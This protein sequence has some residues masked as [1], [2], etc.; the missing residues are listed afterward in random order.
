MPTNR[1]MEAADAIE[2]AR[3]KAKLIRQGILD[4]VDGKAI[5]RRAPKAPT[6][7]W[8][9]LDGGSGKVPDF[10]IPAA[11]PIRLKTATGMTSFHFSHTAVSKVTFE[12]CQDGLRNQPGAA[13]SH[14][15]Y[16]ERE[17]AVAT[18]DGG[19]GMGLEQQPEPARDPNAY[20]PFHPDAGSDETGRHPSRQQENDNEQPPVSRTAEADASRTMVEEFPPYE[21][22]AGGRDGKRSFEDAESDADLQL[23]SGRDLVCDGWGTEHF[24]LGVADVSVETGEG[25]HGLRRPPTGDRADG[26]GEVDPGWMSPLAEQDRYLTRPSSLAILVATRA[27]VTN[28]DCDDDERANF[29]TTVEK[30]ERKPSPDKMKFRGDDHPEFWEHVLSREDCPLEI[31][32]KLA[33]PNR[34]SPKAFTIG[35][36]KQVRAWLR[37]QPGWI[38]P[39]TNKKHSSSDPDAAPLAEF[40][41]GRGGRVQY[42]IAAELPDELTPSQNFALLADFVREFEERE[43]PFVAVMHAPDEHN[44]RKNWHFHIAYYDRPCR[45]INSDDIDQLAHKGFNVAE[46][47]PGMWDFAVEVPVPGRKNRTTFPLR[48]NKV[49]EVSGSKEWPKT[50]RVA[51]AKVV[52]RHLADAGI[53]RRVSPETFEQMGVAADPQEHLGTAQ[54]ALETR[55]VATLVGIENERK[56]WQAIQAQA[57]ARYQADLSEAEAACVR[58]MIRQSPTNDDALEMRR[59]LR[60]KLQQ[61]AKLKYDAL[62]LDQEMERAASRARMVRERNLQLVKA[63]DADPQNA[64]QR[65]RVEH[66]KLVRQA[67]QYLIELEE[68]QADDRALATR[69]RAIAWRCIESARA[70]AKQ[71][72][73]T[74]SIAPRV[75]TAAPPPSAP[76]ISRPMSVSAAPPERTIPPSV[77]PATPQPAAPGVY[78][79]SLSLEEIERRIAEINARG[80]TGGGQTVPND[81]PSDAPAS[82]QTAEQKPKPPTRSGIPPPGLDWGR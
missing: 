75:R 70:I 1:Q 32:A 67:T 9:D 42:R 66:G 59:K 26:K 16:I 69:W 29:W 33:G 28:I 73:T 62:L 39:Q 8:G 72:E 58:A 25:G 2:A 38:E 3:V 81:P 24:L 61:A 48:A 74:L 31:R 76:A 10:H 36:G 12:T 4:P 13:R 53:N 50:L 79:S 57:E 64:N 82:P 5:S 30:H 23:L 51:L 43:L 52:N 49:P 46:L 40:V 45:R 22:D 41:D 71:M 14:G 21:S 54:N 63:C 77:E 15:R 7:A 6:R 19:F 44:H 27:L 80:G 65:E 17:C 68:K 56:Q 11:R 20:S 78:G 34:N 37:K 60:D 18:I 35:S 47:K 55:G